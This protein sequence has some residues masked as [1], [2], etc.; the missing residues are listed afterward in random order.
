MAERADQRRPEEL[1]EVTFQ[2]GFQKHPTGSVLVG[3]GATRVLCAVSVVEGVPKWMGPTE[4]RGW[5]TAEYQMLPGAT[6]ERVPREVSRGQLSGRSA[7]IQRLI[8]RSLRAT[9]DLG[10]VP[11][12]TLYVDCDV[13]DA[14]GGTRCAAVTGACVALELALLKLLAAG[15]LRDWPML[16]RVAGVSVGVVAGE[17]VLDL[18]YAEDSAAAVDMNVVMTSNGQ[19]VEVQGTAEHEPFS[20][21]QMDAMLALAER[22]LRELFR[23]QQ[24]AVTA[25]S[26]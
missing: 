2:A 4:G 13:L 5:L 18:C 11:G 17:P 23:L 3:F 16:R 15:Q 22:G 20:R 21:E 10:R 24:E 26:R 25:G 12:R 6:A 1:R 8:G 9:L 19:F 14:D 7:E